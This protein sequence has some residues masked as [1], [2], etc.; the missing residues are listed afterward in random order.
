[1][2]NNVPYGKTPNGQKDEKNSYFAKKSL[3]M[4]GRKL[5]LEGCMLDLE[6]IYRNSKNEIILVKGVT[7]SGKSHFVRRLLWQFLDINKDVRIK[8][9]TKFPLIF[10]SNQLPTSFSSPL[11]AWR[12]TVKKIY[13]IL[14]ESSQLKYSYKKKFDGEKYEFNCDAVGQIL[15]DSDS[16]SYIN[17]INEILDADIK[18]HFDSNLK[19]ENNFIIADLPPIDNFFEPRKFNGIEKC[20]CNFFT[21]LITSYH[22]LVNSSQGQGQNNNISNYPLIFV[23]EDCNIIDEVID[24]LYYSITNIISI[25]ISIILLIVFIRKTIYPIKNITQ[26]IKNI[27]AQKKY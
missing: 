20:I 15:I 23:L 19:F 4:V 21:K 13:D 26:N 11:N 12:K 17:Y 9:A 27:Q 5:E 24:F 18:K 6:Q 16:Y 2:K 25:T 10:S 22:Q 7:G 3:F 14:K 8:N 1:L